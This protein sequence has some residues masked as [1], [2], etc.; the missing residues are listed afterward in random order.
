MRHCSLN[1]PTTVR[2]KAHAFFRTLSHLAVCLSA[3]LRRQFRSIQLL[4]SH[5]S[6]F[7]SYSTRNDSIIK[8]M[9]NSSDEI[10]SPTLQSHSTSME[11]LKC[12][13]E[14][15]IST[16]TTVLPPRGTLKSIVLVFTVT[17][18]TIINVRRVTG[19]K[20]TFFEPIIIDCE[21]FINFNIY[22]NNSERVELTNSTTPMD[23][24]LIS[25]K[26]GKSQLSCSSH[27]TYIPSLN[28]S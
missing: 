1:F 18:A 25:F 24:I 14:A 15:S 9:S 11:S 28:L 2:L 6:S 22:T 13:N 10:S 3:Y 8:S 7:N 26:F 27:T 20:R 4:G 19:R 17:F 12:A 16:Q 21:F 23:R 5:I